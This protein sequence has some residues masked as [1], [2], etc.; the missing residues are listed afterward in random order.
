METP[1]A[2]AASLQTFRNEVRALMTEAQLGAL[3]ERIQNHDLSVRKFLVATAAPC[4]RRS[5]PWI[6]RIDLPA[7]GLTGDALAGAGAALDRHLERVLV[8]VIDRSA[9]LRRLT[10]VLMSEELADFAASLQR[11]SP[12]LAKADPSR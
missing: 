7:L 3:E 9:L 8:L 5:F 1:N 6:P 11:H 10:P 4:C 2:L 12:I